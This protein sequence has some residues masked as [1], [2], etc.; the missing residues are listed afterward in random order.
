M[1]TKVA[2]EWLE[3]VAVWNTLKRK[4]EITAEER[5]AL[6]ANNLEEFMTC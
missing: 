1:Y 6:G 3:H 5:G 2:V 4:S